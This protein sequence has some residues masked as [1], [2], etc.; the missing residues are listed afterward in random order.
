MDQGKVGRGRQ[1]IR[2]YNRQ[3][4][5]VYQGLVSDD[6]GMVKILGKNFYMVFIYFNGKNVELKYFYYVIF[7]L[8]DIYVF[9]LNGYG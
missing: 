8:L 6:R 5:S 1:V 3:G 9:Y 2:L 4:S 7:Y